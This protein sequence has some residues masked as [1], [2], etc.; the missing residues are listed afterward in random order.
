MEFGAAGLLQV[1]HDVDELRYSASYRYLAPAHCLVEKY[2]YRQ[3]EDCENNKVQATVGNLFIYVH[4]KTF[5]EVSIF[6]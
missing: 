5:F 6:V 3:Q 2:N 4:V 1:W